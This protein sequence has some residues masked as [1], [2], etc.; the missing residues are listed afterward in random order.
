MCVCLRPGAS[1]SAGLHGGCDT[2]R[3]R[4]RR[5]TFA[6]EPMDRDL[7]LSFLSQAIS[8]ASIYL[9]R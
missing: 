8:N 3:L 5:K 1:L 2:T 6:A 9:V 7:F 4:P